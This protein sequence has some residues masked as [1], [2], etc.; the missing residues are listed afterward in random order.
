MSE[1]ILGNVNINEAMLLSNVVKPTLHK[2]KDKECSGLY[3]EDPHS[4]NDD[5]NDEL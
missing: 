3:D 1:A 5:D 2:L 4:G